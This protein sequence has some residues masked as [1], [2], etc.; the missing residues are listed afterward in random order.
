M[1]S[2]L[3]KSDGFT[4]IELMAVL[5]IISIWSAVIVKKVTAISDHAEIHAI[6]QAAEELNTRESLT[7]FQIKMSDA[8]YQ[9][10]AAVWSQYD[11]D[12]GSDYTWQAG[13]TQIGG[14][15]KFGSTVKSL[16]RTPSLPDNPGKWSI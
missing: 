6:I 15:L 9:D 7:W 2:K 16:T 8:G 14:E 5:V 11:R 1:L 12:L 13:P 10:D 4:L 3:S